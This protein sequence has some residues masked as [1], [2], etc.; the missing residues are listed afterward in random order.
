MT[1]EITLRGL[2][3]PVGGI[4]E[5]VL[6]ARR[7]GI[8]HVLLPSKNEKDIKEIKPE[9]LEGLSV[10]YVRRM[11]QVI[12]MTLD[13]TAIRHPGEL[14]TVPTPNNGAPQGTAPS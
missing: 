9:T 7:A 10:H 3:L 4:K 1:G 5:K 2:V 14:F 8:K 11:S 13:T 12:D 6:A